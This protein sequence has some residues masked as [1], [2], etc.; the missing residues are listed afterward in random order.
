MH[1]SPCAWSV[2]GSF[3]ARESDYVGGGGSC[4]LELKA[5]VG[6]VKEVPLPACPSPLTCRV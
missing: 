5:G 6:D 3:Y 1:V 2:S 4:F